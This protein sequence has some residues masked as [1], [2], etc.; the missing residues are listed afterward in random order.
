MSHK[1]FAGWDIGGAHVKAALLDENGKVLTVKQAPCPLWQGLDHLETSLDQILSKF[2]LA[3]T[4]NAVTMTGELVDLFDTRK[5]GVERILGVIK[6]KL[7]CDKLLVFSGPDGLVESLASMDYNQVAS[8]NWL[9]SSMFLLTKIDDGVLVDIGSTTTD[10]IV[11]SQG[12]VLAE[13]YSDYERLI[14]DELVYTGVVRTPLMALAQRMPF[15]NF[16]VGVM[17]EQFATT[18]DIYRMTGELPD[19]AD[20]TPTSDGRTKS[21]DNSARR[22]ARMLGKDFELEQFNDWLKVAQWLSQQQMSRIQQAIERVLSN[23]RLPTTAPIVGAGVG[24]FLVKRVASRLNRAYFDF[25][26]F[27][28]GLKYEKVWAAYCAPAYAV[29]ELCRGTDKS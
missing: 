12:K 15:Q 14:T 3:P 6:R 18:A 24:S 8:A 4:W 20:Q 19:D 10:I 22:L 16:S 29:A 1:T 27:V 7:P 2:P 5:E 26:D 23:A 11:F 17:T 21:R 25:S 9:A 28:D 13:G